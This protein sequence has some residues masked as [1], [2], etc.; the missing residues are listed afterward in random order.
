V[1]KR[2]I[3]RHNKSFGGSLSDDETIKQAGISR[4]TFYKYKKELLGML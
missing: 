3:A 4:K 1:A 2:I